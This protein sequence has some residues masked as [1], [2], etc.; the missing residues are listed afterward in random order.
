MIRK[1]NKGQTTMIRK[2]NKGQTSRHASLA[3][4]V[5]SKLNRVAQVAVQTSLV[6]RPFPYTAWERGWVQTSTVATSL[7]PIPH[8]VVFCSMST[9]AVGRQG[10]CTEFSGVR[11]YGLFWYC[12]ISWSTS[13][14]FLLC[15][16][17]VCVGV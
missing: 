17:E 11:Q 15:S 6:P 12:W 7:I 3:T 13:A 9:T 10:T 1:T 14:I 2:T 4:G 5:A 16:G 8:K